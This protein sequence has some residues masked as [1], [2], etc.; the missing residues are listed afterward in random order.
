MMFTNNQCAKN[1]TIYLQ[2]QNIDTIFISG[3]EVKVEQDIFTEGNV[4][5]SLQ[6]MILK[7]I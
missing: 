7:T 3:T 5:R 2:Q 1:I 6:I 4:K